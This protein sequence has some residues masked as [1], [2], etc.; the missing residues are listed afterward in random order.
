MTMQLWG[1]AVDVVVVGAG[2]LGAATA[3][4]LC[5]GG[6]RVGVL[7]AGAAAGGATGASFSWLN[8]VSKQPEAYHRLNTAGMAAHEALA[9]EVAIMRPLRTG[10][11]ELAAGE[12]NGARLLAK[13]ERLRGWGYAARLIDSAA[14]TILEPNLHAR[15]VTR[16]AYYERDGWIDAPALTRALL[17]VVRGGGGSVR[18]GCTVTGFRTSAG[19]ITGVHTNAGPIDTG[20]VVLCAGIATPW[21]VQQLGAV[22]PVEQEPGLL[23]VTRPVPA[24]LLRRPVYAPGVHLRPDVSGGLRV[25]ADDVDALLREDAPVGAA[26]Q[27]VQILLDRLHAV[28]PALPEVAAAQVHRGVRPVPSDGLTVAG[29]LPG[30]ENGYVAVSHSGIT[31][32]PLLG[33]LLAAEVITGRRD[34]LLAPFRPER[35]V[36]NLT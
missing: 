10:A 6:V 28:L 26:L 13:V 2:M 19:R 30:W 35:F 25:G 36:A 33:H 17:D 9:A 23:V 32:G 27:G 8:A 24:G 5:R 16:I 15:G 1:D 20:A 21:L 14:L 3:Y 29:R 7:D 18:E 12:G 11:L 22:V 4:A 31:L 34:P